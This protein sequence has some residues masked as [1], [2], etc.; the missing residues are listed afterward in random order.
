MT[1]DARKRDLQLWFA[2]VDFSDP[3]L[4]RGL[5]RAGATETGCYSTDDPTLTGRHQE[6]KEILDLMCRISA[7][8][9]LLPAI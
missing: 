1:A 7:D 8:P 4:M 9:V 3:L 2:I 5:E 6:N